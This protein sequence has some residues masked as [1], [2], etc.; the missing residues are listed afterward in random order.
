MVFGEKTAQEGMD[1]VAAAWEALYGEWEE[2][3]GP[4]GARYY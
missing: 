3:Y 4:L 1:A 2:R